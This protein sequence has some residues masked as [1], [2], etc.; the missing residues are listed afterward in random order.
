MPIPHPSHTRARTSPVQTA[1]RLLLGA[2]LV[3]AGTSHLTWS[4]LERIGHP[5]LL[6]TGDGDLYVPP[7]LMR[8]QAQ[9]LPTA[10]TVVIAEAGHSP[11][12]ERP[13]IFNRVVLDFLR[14]LGS[15]IDR[16][17][18]AELDAR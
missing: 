13:A 18:E 16:Q 6:M 14:S 1:F 10:E 7:A 8:M 11:Y 3:F 12:W 9:H 4:R 5:V 2:A 17:Q 15:Q